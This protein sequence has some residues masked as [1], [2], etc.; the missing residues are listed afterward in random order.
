MSAKIIFLSLLVLVSG[1]AVAQNTND[2]DNRKE[3]S[4]MDL[5]VRFK[6]LDKSGDGKLDL[7]ELTSAFSSVPL[8]RRPGGV[9][10]NQGGASTNPPQNQVGPPAMSAAEFFKSADA[11]QDDVLTVD[12]FTSMVEKIRAS[13]RSGGGMGG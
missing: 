11:D 13:G 1:M 4:R 2:S 7:D 6:Q 9:Q 10:S 12:E 3:T 5:A 8:G